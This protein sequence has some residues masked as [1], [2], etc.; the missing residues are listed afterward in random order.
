M[1][2]AAGLPFLA[3]CRGM[4]LLNVARGGSL[5]QH[6]PDAVGHARHAPDQAR[7]SEHQVRIEADSPLGQLLGTEAKVRASHHQ[8]VQ[9]LGT[10]LTAAAWADDGVVE[11]IVLT[12][13]RFGIGVQWHPE[14]DSDL[15][16]IR[17][18]DSHGGPRSLSWLAAAPRP[19][20]AA[21]DLPRLPGRGGPR[22]SMIR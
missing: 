19:R 3:V 9:R 20:A 2:I 12:G 7:L 11:A 1:P 22:S 13:H 21:G 16:D 18:A 8:A 6:L 10:G 15:R 5:I 4:H 14:E 17:R